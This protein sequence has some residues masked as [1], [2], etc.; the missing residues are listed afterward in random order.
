VKV[1]NRGWWLPR[2]LATIFLAVPLI[3][4]CGGGGGDAGDLPVTMTLRA[5]AT[6]PG[7]VDLSWTAA[8]A[9][10]NYRVYIDGAYLGTSFPPNTSVSITTLTPSSSHCFR[11]FA[12]VFLFGIASQS[13]EACVTTP[14]SIKPSAPANLTA[15]VVS[16]G[17]INLAWAVSTGDFI[18][19]KIYRDASYLA[20]TS[21]TSYSDMSVMSSTQY[22]YAVSA[23]DQWG[24]ES[25]KSSAACAT[26]PV[27]TEPPSLPT[28]VKAVYDPGSAANPT[29]NLSWKAAFDNSGTVS[30]YRIYRDSAF[31]A[32]VSELQYSDTGLQTQKQYC[33]GVTAVDNANNESEAG[34]PA[35]ATTSWVSTTVDSTVSATWTAIAV[36]PDDKPH[37]AYYDGLYTGPYLQVGTVKYATNLNGAWQ[38]ATVDSVAPTVYAS[39]AL[40]VNSDGSLN[41]AYYDFNKLLLK[42]ATKTS[43]AWLIDTIATNLSAVTT[44]A[45]SHDAA[46]KLHVIVNPYGAITYM[47]NVTGSWASEMIGSNGV[48]YGDAATC[49]I[50]IDFM[51]KA[52]VG[53]YDYPNHTLQYVTNG[54]GTWVAETIDNAGNVGLHTAIAVDGGGKVHVSYY[55][56]SNGDLKYATNAMGSWTTQTIDSVGDVGLNGAI[57]VDTNGYV[58]ISYTDATNHSLKYA[59]NSSGAW[60]TYTIDSST[61]V[62]GYTSLGGYTSIAV[63]SNGKIHI[64]Y[65]G[66]TV[67]RYATNL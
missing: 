2:L 33:Y 35:C 19:Y 36:D 13:N 14:P 62:G 34:G 41:I 8:S 20:S 44:V 16:P 42:R 21:V 66:D 51:G 11:V 55:D 37:I 50:S 52:H 17:Q 5:T 23:Y 39:I 38:S 6:G 15:D 57:A 46:A 64:S 9:V 28:S 32:Q 56:I 54:S 67:L 60:M 22:C 4:G 49:A 10:T 45:M 7:S 48:I 40:L 63:D 25:A 65:R 59:S 18:G 47:N 12:F 53:Y 1:G 31:I 58:H 3:S 30:A 27:D 29:I 24:Y 26:T 43:G 61:Y